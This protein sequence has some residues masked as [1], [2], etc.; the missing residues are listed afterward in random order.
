MA[1]LLCGGLGLPLCPATSTRT[2]TTT[3]ATTLSSSSFHSTSALSTAPSITSSLAVSILRPST[4]SFISSS[5]STP[6][7]VLTTRFT[8]TSSTT[9]PAQS[10]SS[11][12]LV[13]SGPTCPTADGQAFTARTLSRFIRQRAIADTHDLTED[14][15]QYL[16]VCNQGYSSNSQN[17]FGLA[18]ITVTSFA[19][20]MYLCSNQGS[21]CGGVAYGYFGDQI[22]QCNLKSKMLRDNQPSNYT[23]DAAVRMSGPSG[24]SS[25]SELLLNGGFAG[26]IRPWTTN[27]FK[28]AVQ[29]DAATS[30]WNLAESLGYKASELAQAV[31]LSPGLPYYLNFSLSMSILGPIEATNW[32][33]FYAQTDYET[34]LFFY[35]NINTYTSPFSS[36]FN[37]SGTLTRAANRFIFFM[38]CSGNFNVTWT[39]NSVALHTYLP[40]TGANPLVPQSSTSILRNGNF[41]SGLQHWRWQPRPN[42]NNIVVSPSSITNLLLPPE[43]LNNATALMDSMTSSSLVPFAP[44]SPQQQQQQQALTL[45]AFPTLSPSTPTFTSGYLTQISPLPI[46]LNQT[47]RLTATIYFNVSSSCS[48]DAGIYNTLYPNSGVNGWAWSVF[49]IKERRVV[50]VNVTGRATAGNTEFQVYVGCEGTDRACGVGVGGLEMRVNV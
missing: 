4:L 17:I 35:P 33:N 3:T 41:T 2:R 46:S 12:S 10:P 22:L 43:T 27:T 16:I 31:N 13:P 49:G 6:V 8:S 26:S 20:C 50:Q 32:C 23:I 30:S 47:F 45:I 1:A 18:P 7:S 37:A 42:F 38:F 14:G 15:S 40:S 24:P 19:D 29:E 48:C 44:L 36:K 5:T 9:S 34:L 28:L 21:I 25:R 39:I 11:T